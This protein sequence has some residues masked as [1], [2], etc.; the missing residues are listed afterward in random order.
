MINTSTHQHINTST[1]QHINTM[2]STHQHI[3]TST[4]QH[5]NS[6]TVFF[7][8]DWL[9]VNILFCEKPKTKQNKTKQNKNKQNKTKQ[10]T[11]KQT[12]RKCSRERDFKVCTLFNIFLN[13]SIIFSSFHSK[14]FFSISISFA[15]KVSHHHHHR[16][17]LHKTLHP[18]N[19]FL[20]IFPV[21]I[22]H[23]FHY[24]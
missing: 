4:H 10:Q 24:A 1:H 12:R 2:S 17:E 3:N 15:Q 21:W 16:L 19:H 5:I 22:C 8:D 11:N 6:S 14:H 20:L 7:V 18:H 9:R 23:A 13:T